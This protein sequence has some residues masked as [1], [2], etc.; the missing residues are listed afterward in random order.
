VDEDWAIRVLEWWIDHATDARSRGNG[1]IYAFAPR[2]NAKVVAL[3]EREDQTRQ[4]VARTLNLDS[5][6][7][8]ITSSGSDGYVSLTDGVEVC[9][10]ALGR[11]RTQAETLANLGTSAPAMKADAMHPLIWS[12]ASAR[13]ASGH[14][15]DAVQRS[16]TFLNA[17][18]QDLVGR[19]DVADSELMRE[20]FSQSRPAEGKPRLRWPGG[21]DDLTVRAMRIGI[22]NFSQG[23]YSAIRN[24]A[25]HSTENMERQ[26]ALEQLATLSILARWVDRCDVVEMKTP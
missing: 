8:L 7:Q 19:S 16:A 18:I 13:W 22:L 2:D 20:V 4:V 23:I 12:T 15:S 3:R 9:K 17:H 26:E 10:Y 21:D 5:L 25:T 6:P 24:P 11:L 14:F 1:Q